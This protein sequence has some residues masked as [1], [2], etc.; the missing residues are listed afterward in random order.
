MSKIEADGLRKISVQFLKKYGYFKGWYSGVITW[1][2]GWSRDKNSVGVV[3][4]TNIPDP[5]LRIYYTQTD[6]DTGEKKDFDYKVLLTTTPCRYGGERYW[7]ICPLSKNGLYCGKR[8]GVLYKV[9][10]YFGC[11]H[12]YDLT[13]ESRNLSGYAKQFGNISCPDVDELEAKVKRTHYKG[14]PT[15]NYVR[16]L[17]ANDKLNNAFI[18]MANRLSMK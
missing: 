11:R 6:R 18:G 5:Y 8:I 17:R 1:I 14:K 9:G 13:Y 3:S 7:F 10:D 15:R 2:S 16:Y 12:C 4:N